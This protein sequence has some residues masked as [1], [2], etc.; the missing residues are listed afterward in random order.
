MEE[1]MSIAISYMPHYTDQ[2]RS[3]GAKMQRSNIHGCGDF[4]YRV[5]TLG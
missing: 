1:L 3:A 2:W 5:W 4:L